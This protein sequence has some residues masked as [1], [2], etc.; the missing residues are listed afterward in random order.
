MSDLKAETAPTLY[1]DGAFHQDLWTTLEEGADLSDMNNVLVP[2][3]QAL[4]LFVARTN[5]PQAFGV[6]VGAED[7]VAELAPYLDKIAVIDVSFPGFGD[8]RSF[9][10]ARLLKER[11]GFN[12]EIRA[13]G[14]Y[15]LDQMPFLVRCG[16]DSFVISSPK[17]RVGLERG[18]WPEVTNYYQPTGADGDKTIARRPWL[19]SKQSE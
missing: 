16:V 13:V 9:S 17:V 18:D 3:K 7:D 6:V 2:F 10:S 8:G 19:R 12:G 1:R 5:L 4:E 14:N 11:F 15:I